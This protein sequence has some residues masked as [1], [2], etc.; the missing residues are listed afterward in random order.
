[1]NGV[2]LKVLKSIHHE[3]H[4]GARRNVK[5][6]NAK[7][8]KDAKEN[9]QMTIHVRHSGEGRIPGKLPMPFLRVLRG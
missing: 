1:M 8:A 5:S 6:L 4:E 9:K 7:D 2:I 3:G